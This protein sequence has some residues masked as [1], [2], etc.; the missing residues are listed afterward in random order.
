[1]DAEG[2][3]PGLVCP[4]CKEIAE[5]EPLPGLTVMRPKWEVPASG[6]EGIPSRASLLKLVP[7]RN[8]YKPGSSE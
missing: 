4:G 3:I 1:M 8:G 7:P 2:G 5:R 6:V